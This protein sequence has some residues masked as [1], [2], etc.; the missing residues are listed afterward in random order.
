[1]K[2]TM[3]IPSNNNEMPPHIGSKTSHQDQFINPVSFKTMKAMVSRPKKPIPEFEAEE[4]LLIIAVIYSLN[5]GIISH[6]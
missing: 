2:K 6:F 5:L 3:A 4:L 1:M